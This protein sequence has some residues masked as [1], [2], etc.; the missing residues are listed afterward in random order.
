M[1]VNSHHRPPLIRFRPAL[2]IVAA[3][4]GGAGTTIVVPLILALAWSEPIMPFLIPLGIAL[5]LLTIAVSADRTTLA[6]TRREAILAAVLTWLGLAMFG[7][8]PYLLGSAPGGAGNPIDAFF[9]S[10]SGFTAT[11]ATVMTDLDAQ[12]RA[13]LFWRSQ[14]QWIGGIGLIVLA[15]IFMQRLAVG[16]RQLIATEP[17]GAEIEKLT[18]R[19]RDSAVRVV[20]V[21]L[22]LT[23]LLIVGL[24]VLGAAG[25]SP[26]MGVYQAITHAFTTVSA[27]GF[28]PQPGSIEAFGPWAQWLILVAI[29]VAGTNLALWFR[30]IAQRRPGAFRD[31]ELRWY[32]IIL[33]FAGTLVSLEVIRSDI[34]GVTDGVRNGAFTAA[35]IMTGTGYASADFAAWPQLALGTLFL[36]MFVG[37]CAGSPTGAL[38]VVRLMLVSKTLGRETVGSLHPEQVRAIRI[39]GRVVGDRTVRSALTYVLL[40]VVLVI[41]AS[42]ALLLDPGAPGGLSYQDSLSAIAATLGN[43][44]PGFGFFGP[45]GSYAPF[46]DQAKALMALLMVTGR[47][48]IFPLLLLLTR[49]FWRA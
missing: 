18:P 5:G 36:L 7:A 35:S 39:G 12:G 16:G 3:I 48:E 42:V 17:S 40:Y 26:G 47:L 37:G 45:M 29:V 10:A 38:K 44:G 34:Y 49:T 31:E 1:S 24:I 4:V 33:G 32:L 15:V 46:S 21:Y 30:A 6:P 8:L 11:G 22:V 27:G 23:A 41:V 9:E 13:L 43:V 25:L 14:T 19:L 20:S 2:W 28:S